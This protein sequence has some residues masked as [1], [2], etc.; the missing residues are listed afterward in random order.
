MPHREE[1]PLAYARQPH[2]AAQRLLGELAPLLAGHVPIDRALRLVAAQQGGKRAR[3]AALAL[4]AALRE[5]RPLSLAMEQARD[6]YGSAAIA[7][8]RAGESSGNLAESLGRY[9]SYLRKQ[10]EMKRKLGSS[11][12]YPATVLTVALV[13]IA[14]LLGLV[15]PRMSALLEALGNGEPALPTRILLSLSAFIRGPMFLW[16]LVPALLFVISLFVHGKGRISLIGRLSLRL[17]V[18]GAAVQ[19]GALARMCATLAALLRSGVPLPEGLR[20][21]GPAS[22]NL[23][24]ARRVEALSR[25]VERGLPL[26]GLMRGITWRGMDLAAEAAALGEETGELAERLDWAA[27]ELEARSVARSA[28]L[29]AL[30]EP[31]LIIMMALVVGLVAASLFMPVLALAERAGG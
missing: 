14:L 20:L 13:A 25:D 24:L 28:T 27:G 12:A 19:M 9:V 5:G 6:F 21:A 8:A 10:A 23:V 7:A 2:K 17:P 29:L 15:V 22:G 26:S 11:L 18:L 30:L 4:E 31:A 3:E 1:T 16:A